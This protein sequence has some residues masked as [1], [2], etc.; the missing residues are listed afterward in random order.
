MHKSISKYRKFVKKLLD[1]ASECRTGR[2]PKYFLEPVDGV[3]HTVGIS[4]T[5]PSSIERTV[6]YYKYKIIIGY[7]ADI[8]IEKCPG[9][10]G[11]EKFNPILSVLVDPRSE[12]ASTRTMKNVPFEWM[13]IIQSDRGLFRDNGYMCMEWFIK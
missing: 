6:K 4:P 5:L 13:K 7:A 11:L 3:W 2:G 8:E 12:L 9:Q 1:T 10:S